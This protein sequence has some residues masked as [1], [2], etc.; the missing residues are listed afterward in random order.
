MPTLTTEGL[1]AA[2]LGAPTAGMGDGGVISFRRAGDDAW[3]VHWGE[4]KEA[5]ASAFF[6]A[7]R[8]T[9]PAVGLRVTVRPSIDLRRHH[10]LF[11]WAESVKGKLWGTVWDVRGG[12]VHVWWDDDSQGDYDFAWLTDVDW[13]RRRTDVD[14]WRGRPEWRQVERLLSSNVMSSADAEAYLDATAV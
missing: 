3:E 13:W 11:Q 5:S 1:R 7:R 14:W 8:S 6:P 4:T 12:I 10:A 9:V 2:I